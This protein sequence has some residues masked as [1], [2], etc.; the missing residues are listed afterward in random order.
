[1]RRKK[2]E[3]FLYKTRA[4]YLERRKLYLLILDHIRMNK[5]LED[6]LVSNS[7]NPPGVETH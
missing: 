4:E 2:K 1:M 5:A 6:S 7:F 3:I